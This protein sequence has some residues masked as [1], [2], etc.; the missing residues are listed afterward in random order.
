MRANDKIEATKDATRTH[1]EADVEEDVVRIFDNAAL[2]LGGVHGVDDEHATPED[3]PV[4]ER[5]EPE[6]RDDPA[7][8]VP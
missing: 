7:I 2:C 8:F 6:H 1:E 4:R 3:G 5:E